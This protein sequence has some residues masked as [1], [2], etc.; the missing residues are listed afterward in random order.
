[1]KVLR[2]ARN[3]ECGSYSGLAVLLGHS[4]R[5]RLYAIRPDVSSVV[6]AV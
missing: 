5:G 4:L 6:R 3:G 1:M 2:G